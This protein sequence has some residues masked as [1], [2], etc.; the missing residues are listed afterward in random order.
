MKVK[1]TEIQSSKIFGAWGHASGKTFAD[2]LD[3]L[4]I[5]VEQT[6]MQLPEVAKAEF[7]ESVNE[8]LEDFLSSIDTIVS[9]VCRNTA[10][11]ELTSYILRDIALEE[12][13]RYLICIGSSLSTLFLINWCRRY[14]FDRPTLFPKTWQFLDLYIKE[15]FDLPILFVPSWIIEEKRYWS[16]IAHEIGH[17]IEKR[18]KIVETFHE[19]VSYDDRD[20][21]EGRN[22]F[23][24]REYVS[25]YFANA[26]FG[27]IYYEVAYVILHV[28]KIRLNE[29]HPPYDARLYMLQNELK[30]VNRGRHKVEE[31]PSLMYSD[32]PKIDAILNNTRTLLVNN[33]AYYDEGK[34][35]VNL[36]MA[37]DSLESE[38]VYIGS[39][40]VLLNGYW[41]KRD[42]IAAAIRR[43]HRD[44]DQ[45]EIEKIIGNLIGDSIRLTNMKRTYEIMT[46]KVEEKK[47][48]S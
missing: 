22:Y 21:P 40:R 30:D 7:L 28:Y 31:K 25:D 48:A 20:T 24:S 34:I 3:K 1:R 19:E 17:I 8:V 13:V 43:R 37:V 38:L 9:S 5:D 15:S 26:Y 44:A 39:P 2:I 32:I 36:K 14:L 4:T 6:I 35:R 23:H 45:M 42:R 10:I 41:E 27:P 12:K 46:K 29:T 11:H 18:F 16:A 33:C 47:A